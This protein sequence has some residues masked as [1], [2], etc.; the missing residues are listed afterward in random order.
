MSKKEESIK[1]TFTIVT[2]QH[3]PQIDISGSYKD[4]IIAYL[5][6]LS[7]FG[8][9]CEMKKSGEIKCQGEMYQKYS[10]EIKDNLTRLMEGSNSNVIGQL[11]N[12]FKQMNFGD[13]FAFFPQS[14]TENEISIVRDDML[15]GF[16]GFQYKNYKS[17]YDNFWKDIQ[18]NYAIISYDNGHNTVQSIGEKERKNRICRFCGL[19]MPHTSFKNKSHSISEALGN[20]NIVTNDECDICN[21]KFGMGI[22]LDLINLLDFFRVYYG[23]QG[24]GGKKKFASSDFEIL[25]DDIQNAL[26]INILDKN[27][28]ADDKNNLKIQLK[29]PQKINLQNVYRAL[30]KYALSVLDS[31]CLHNFQETIKWVKSECSCNELPWVTILVTNQKSDSF[32]IINVF[33]RKSD[34]KE[35]PYSFMTLE[36]DGLEIIAL[37]P[38]SSK[39][40]CAFDND[41]DFKRFWNFLKPYN[42]IPIL[43]RFKP[44]ADE[45]KEFT[46]NL[47]FHQ[48][49]D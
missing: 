30:V 18:D 21:K 17:Y 3:K 42:Q 31:S 20:K 15:K 13:P 5:Q 44:V 19:K 7:A 1:M 22:E 2:L 33:V 8:A 26:S 48:K 41:V 9:K 25:K 47:S 49:G 23:I 39:D 29:H 6:V 46:Y 35:L 37:L 32:P 10:P 36:I 12:I 34:T 4:V 27:L 38:L 40:D 24:K 43:Q 14:L 11:Y 45:A 16:L 28:I